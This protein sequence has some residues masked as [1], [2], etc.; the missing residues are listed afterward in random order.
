MGSETKRGRESEGAREETEREGDERARREDELDLNFARGGDCAF[1]KPP[2]QA[3]LEA[4]KAARRARRDVLDAM[5][6][7]VEREKRG[8]ERASGVARGQ[9]ERERGSER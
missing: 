4:Q 1:L 7:K 6:S 5:R 3:S 9:R 2:R 8:G